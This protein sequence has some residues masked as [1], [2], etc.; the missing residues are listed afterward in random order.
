MKT[1]YIIDPNNYKG[2]I[3]NTMTSIDGTPEYVDYMKEATTFEQYK[4]LKGNDDLVALEWEV[5]EKEYRIPYLNS[6][7]KPFK[8]CTEAYF[9]N[10]LEC[11]PP[12]RWT[13]NKALDTE[14][15][16]LGECTTDDLYDCYVRKGEKYYSALRSISTPA[17]EL[18]NLN[19]VTR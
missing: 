10:A 17:D 11:V 13:Q 18:G 12:K 5:F 16:F 3:I 6:L 7:C 1:L 14:F 15:F 2:Q 19:E 8:E 9:W 4:K